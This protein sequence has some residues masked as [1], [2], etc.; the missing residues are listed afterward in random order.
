MS[1]SNCSKNTIPSD[2]KY[3]SRPFLY[4]INPHNKLMRQILLC[5]FY[6]SDNRF[7]KIK[8]TVLDL[9]GHEWQDQDPRSLWIQRPHFPLQNHKYS[10]NSY[11]LPKHLVFF[12]KLFFPL[13]STLY[14]L[15]WNY[16][17]KEDS[18]VLLGSY[19][20]KY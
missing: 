17:D 13:L 20:L 8:Y 12:F 1:E 11:R 14:V 6:K 3:C 4:T 7:K 9:V 5:I 15:A 19:S 18:K 10:N 2:V 16:S